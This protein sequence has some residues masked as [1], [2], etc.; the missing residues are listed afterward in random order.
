MAKWRNIFHKKRK[1]ESV[2]SLRSKVDR[3]RTLLEQ[4]NF[5]LEQMAEASESLGG[6]LL[7]DSQYLRRLAEQLGDAVRHIILDLN[8]IT[9]NRYPDLMEVFEKVQASVAEALE[10]PQTRARDMVVEMEHPRA[11]DIRLTGIQIK[12]SD[13]PG[14]IGLPPPMLGQHSAEILA[15]WLGMGPVD[16]KNLATKKVI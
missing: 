14:E 10:H 7:F 15:D 11:G 2:A 3:F 4:N 16:I 13:T 5:V 9:D 6:D 12:L 1:G 8:R